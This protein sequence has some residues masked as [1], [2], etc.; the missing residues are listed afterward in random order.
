MSRQ[1]LTHHEPKCYFNQKFTSFF[2]LTA[3]FGSI[4]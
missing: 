3:K 4:G 1:V 2:A